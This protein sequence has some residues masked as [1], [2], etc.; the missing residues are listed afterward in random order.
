M[1]VLKQYSFVNTRTK[2]QLDVTHPALVTYDTFQGQCTE[3]I[4]TMLEEN[5]VYIVMYLQIVQIVWPKAAKEFL[6]K[7]FT[8]WYSDQICQQLRRGIKPAKVIDLRP[9]ARG[10][11]D[12]QFI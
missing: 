6:R 5:N 10:P 1:R 7:Q 4:L 11:V 2:N 12:D 3:T 9:N 8:E